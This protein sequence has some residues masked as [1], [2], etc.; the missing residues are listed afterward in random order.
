LALAQFD[1]AWAV[2]NQ[3]QMRWVLVRLVF[4][5][6]GILGATGVFVLGF[7]ITRVAVM[8]PGGARRIVAALCVLSILG[9]PLAYWLFVD[10]AL[11]HQQLIGRGGSARA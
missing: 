11:R 4:G 3:L 8:L 2:L 9:I 6:V 5:A 7:R 10:P 1:G